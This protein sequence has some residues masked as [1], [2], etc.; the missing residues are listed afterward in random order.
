MKT[1][2]SL[3]GAFAASALAHGTVP[4]FRVDGVAHGGFLLDYYYAKVNGQAVPKVAGWY[5]ENLDNGFV[6]PDAYQTSDINCHKNA[7]P[8][9]AS[10]QVAA[11]GTVDFLWSAWPD[12][13]KGPVFTYVAKCDADCT[14]ADKDTLKWVKIDEAGIDLTTQVW[15]AQDLIANN[16]TWTTTV[17]ST[18]APGNYVFRHEIIAMHGAG[19][20]NGAQNYPQ[21][22]NI[23]ITG[24]GTD[25]PEGVLGTELY[26]ADHPGILFNPYTT[27]TSY[28]MPGPALYGGSNSTAASLNK[29]RRNHARSFHLRNLKH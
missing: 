19:S 26:T 16:N 7:A 20:E 18:L 24:S 5:A 14:S 10:V 1:S 17:P 3:L 6:A 2:V 11:G 25:N 15:A 27:L 29:F 28:E 12:S 21:C 9:E 23:E 13:H 4:N 22:F 8:G